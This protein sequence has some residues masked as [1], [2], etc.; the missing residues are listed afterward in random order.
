MSRFSN[1]IFA[2]KSLEISPA[3][4]NRAGAVP[5]R[6][7]LHSDRD[8]V[9]LLV[10]EIELST[11]DSLRP[12]RAV[13]GSPRPA[14]AEEMVFAKEIQEYNLMGATTRVIVPPGLG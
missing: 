2:G 9:P 8:T 12:G 3:P 14:A 13:S 10:A 6:K 5:H 11:A 4:T 7:N 1:F